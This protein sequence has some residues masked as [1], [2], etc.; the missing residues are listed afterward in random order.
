MNTSFLLSLA[1]ASLLQ[2]GLWLFAVK[3]RNAGW[4]DFG[5][6][7]GMWMSSIFILIHSDYSLRAW[8]A[9]GILFFWSGRL[10][11][12]ILTDR[13]LGSKEEDTRYQNLRKHWGENANRRFFWVFESQALLVLLFMTPA[14]VVTRRAGASPDLFDLL[15]LGV[16]GF[17]I[18]GETLADRQLA[19]FR[20]DPSTKGKV[21]QRGLWRY[22]RHPNYFFEWL[23]WF[24]YVLMGIGSEVWIFTL[25]G[26]ILMYV[27]L[28][29]VTGVPH[30]ERQS[31]RSRGDAYRE[32]QQ[33]TPVF[34]PWIPRKP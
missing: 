18:L 19:A 32:Y 9:C 21:C 12:H 31:L 24:G 11:L 16:A 7:A 5:W 4:V 15:G 13:L 34:F 8:L 22:S 10:A 1:S 14:W 26:P 27:F 20:R 28:R 3:T 25:L 30:A 33:S 23:H 29:Y 17:S 6:S 2:G